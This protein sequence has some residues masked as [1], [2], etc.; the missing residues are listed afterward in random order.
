[1]TETAK[2]TRVPGTN[3]ESDKYDLTVRDRVW[4]ATL[5]L[6]E[7]RPL[8]LKLWRIRQRAGLDESHDRTIRRTLRSMEATGWLSRPTENSK[9]WEHGPKFNERFQ[10]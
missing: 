4:D 6:L 10:K 3:V 5:E 2:G 1:M 9:R 7:E 8:G